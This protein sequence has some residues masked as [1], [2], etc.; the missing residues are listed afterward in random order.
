MLCRRYLAVIAADRQYAIFLAVLPLVLSLLARAVPGEA[1]LSVAAAAAAGNRQPGLLLLV[2]VV[3][4]ALMGAAAAIRELVKERPIYVHERAVGLSSGAYL[5]SKIVVLTVVVGLQATV[6]TAAA[7]AGRPGPTIRCSPGNLEI[8]L[9]VLLVGVATMLMGLVISAMID[10]A[11]RGMPLLV[12][13]IMAQLVFSGGLFPVHG[14]PGLEQL[15]WLAPARWAFAMSAA[16]IDLAAITPGQP[17]RSGGTTA[18]SGRATRP[19]SR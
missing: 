8:L 6:F 7:L 2:L 15:A 9:A 14:R 13:M 18:R 4:A 10:N 5:L 17:I 16:S 19:S 11:D 1:G 12:L 3:G